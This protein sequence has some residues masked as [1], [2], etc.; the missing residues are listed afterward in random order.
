LEVSL[1]LAFALDTLQLLE[2]TG[3]LMWLSLLP[4]LSLVLN[5]A[6]TSFSELGG[7]LGFSPEEAPVGA[8]W[9]TLHCFEAPMTEV[10]VS[11]LMSVTDEEAW[12][13]VGLFNPPATI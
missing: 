6:L 3:V 9:H 2:L 8:R 13:K 4:G 10:V 12:E 7:Y 1:K 5:L 11:A